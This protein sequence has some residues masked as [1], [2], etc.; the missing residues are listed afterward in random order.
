M[1]CPAVTWSSSTAVQVAMGQVL[2]AVSQKGTLLAAA[3]PAQHPT[4][5]FIFKLR[6]DYTPKHFN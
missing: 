1:L 5:G 3:S 2:V 6:S 4:I